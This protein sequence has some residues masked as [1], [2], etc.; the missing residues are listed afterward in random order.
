MESTGL[1]PK[2]FLNS[3]NGLRGKE[4]RR[5]RDGS[6]TGHPF[7]QKM[8]LSEWFLLKLKKKKK[9]GIAWGSAEC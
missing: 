5:L 2:A 6:I 7:K 8:G 3:V 9:L 4:I 1:L